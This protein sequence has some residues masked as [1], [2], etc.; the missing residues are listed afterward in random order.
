[1][2]RTEAVED[3]AGTRMLA[4]EAELG[5]AASHQASAARPQ[6]VRPLDCRAWR[7]VYCLFEVYVLT[8]LA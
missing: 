8:A 7:G 2:G 4:S 6:G 5:G 1:M 3:A